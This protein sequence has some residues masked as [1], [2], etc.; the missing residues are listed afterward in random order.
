MERTVAQREARLQ[1]VLPCEHGQASSSA[2]PSSVP[3]RLGRRLC[4]G[5]PLEAAFTPCQF[6]RK[7][8]N[9]VKLLAHVYL[10]LAS[11]SPVYPLNYT[12]TP[13]ERAIR[14]GFPK[15]VTIERTPDGR[16]GGN[17]AKGEGR[18]RAKSLSLGAHGSRPGI[19]PDSPSRP[20]AWPSL[21]VGASAT[22]CASQC[23]PMTLLPGTPVSPHCPHQPCFPHLPQVAGNSSQEPGVGQPASVQSSAR[24]FSSV[25]ERR[26]SDLSV[27]QCPHL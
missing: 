8:T 2:A 10:T 26:L 6:P 25:T 16:A 12:F 24:A 20:A 14:E 19:S 22:V 17:K 7:A 23:P 27:T 9:E 5:L 3:S 11:E 4:S 15:D 18:A 1:L 21:T 13:S